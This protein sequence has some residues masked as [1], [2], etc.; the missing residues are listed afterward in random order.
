M[1]LFLYA[2]PQ[3]NRIHQIQLQSPDQPRHTDFRD[4]EEDKEEDEGDE[5]E[6]TEE[7]QSKDQNQTQEN[8]YHNQDHFSAHH[9]HFYQ[10]YDF[11]DDDDWT[12]VDPRKP[13]SGPAVAVQRVFRFYWPGLW[14]AVAS[15]DISKVIVAM[16]Y[17]QITFTI[18]SLNYL[19]T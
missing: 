16:Y 5:E 10:D 7:Y 15:E 18:F 17:F 9:D 3:I 19:Q 11:S 8:S 13:A 2:C 14:R 1:T 12:E 4:S 6:D